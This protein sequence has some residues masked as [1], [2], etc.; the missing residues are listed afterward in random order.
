MADETKVTD[1]GDEYAARV[2]RGGRQIWRTKSKR[3]YGEGEALAMAMDLQRELEALY[4][5]PEDPMP[6]LPFY[7]QPQSRSKWGWS[8]IS[9]TIHRGRQGDWAEPCFVVLTHDDGNRVNTRF[10]DHH[11]HGGQDQAHRAAILHR[12]R[13]E[14]D[15]LGDYEPTLWSWFDRWNIP[16]WP[17]L[18]E[19][20]VKVRA[21]REK[22][23]Q[24][25][26][27]PQRLTVPRKVKP[28]R[29][30]PV[31]ET[32]EFVFDDGFILDL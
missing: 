27:D 22:M 32:D 29:S 3:K 11:Y 10:Y 14:L 6:R 7:R 1:L 12:V 23:V 15:A 31:T 13:W 17:E 25:G 26:G 24:A 19:A 8:G 28:G 20:L 4:P 9:R 21:E 2:Y 16:R 30:Q 5:R 18:Q